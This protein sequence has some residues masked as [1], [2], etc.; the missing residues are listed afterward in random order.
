VVNVLVVTSEAV[1][2][3]KTGGLGDVCGA[4]PVELA[5]QGQRP[6]VI[7]PGYRQAYAAGHTIEPLGIELEIPI[8]SKTVKG[9]LE[10]GWLPGGRVPVYFVRQD[11]YFDR[12]ALYG[13]PAGDYQDNCERFVFFCRAVM[14]A[15]RL[16]D[17]PVDVLHCNDWQTALVCAYLRIEYRAV[18][19][20]ENIASL[21]T[22][23]NMAFQG[24]FWHWDMLLTGL[25]WKYFNWREMEYFGDL[26]LMK[27]GLVFAD[28]LSTV[29]RR[30]AEEIQT[31]EF[32]CGLE[33]V[34]YQRRDHLTGILNGVDYSQWD[35]ATDKHLVVPYTPATVKEGKARAKEALQVEL[36]LPVAPEVP[37][38]GMVGRMTDQKGWDLIVKVM[39]EWVQ[40]TDVQWVALG[41]GEPKYEQQI[42]AIAKR[43][44]R[45]VAARIGFSDPLAHRIEAGADM[46]LMPSRYEPCGLNQMYSLKYGTPPVVRATGGLADTITNATDENLAAG[47]A[48]GF[49]FHEASVLAL[50]ETLR[51]AY[52]M[53]RTRPEQWDRLIETGMS[54]D[55]SW[56][57]SAEQYVELY[58]RLLARR[59]SPALAA[60]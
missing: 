29:S 47:T 45:R 56:R 6:A 58:Q 49:S 24:R 37:V 31:Q 36:G 11:E 55:W 15:I 33:G 5:R 8:G 30:Y 40:T 54:Q 12:D 59:R 42:E 7:M 23:H 4:L 39:S 41:T 46:F 22:I 32:G 52:D 19:R 28:G 26:N 43:V 57:R 18:P 27:T 25:D 9:S 21:L 1:P 60:N 16:V 50:S 10:R 13:T 35:P 51:R 44:P 14:E 2:F 3:A 34:L 38:V 48:N 53:Y 20:Y 17:L